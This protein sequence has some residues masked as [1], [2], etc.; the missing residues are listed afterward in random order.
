MSDLYFTTVNE[1]AAA[2]LDIT[3]DEYA[4]CNYIAV[5]S[6][7]PRNKV[8]GYCERTLEQK[9]AFIRIT[10]RGLTKMQNRM[11]EI[12]LLEKA[13]N[14]PLIRITKKWFEA[15]HGKEQSSQSDRE[16]SS[17]KQGTK[18][19]QTGNKVPTHIYS[20]Y[21]NNTTTTKETKSDFQSKNEEPNGHPPQP[22]NQSGV[23]YRPEEIAAKFGD[24]F[25]IRDAFS[26]SRGMPADIFE[27][28]LRGFIAEISGTGETYSN[29]PALVRHFL[30][31]S[32]RSQYYN[33]S[34]KKHGPTRR[35][36]ENDRSVSTHFDPAKG[37][38]K[39]KS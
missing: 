12:G 26:I 23:I 25:L 6:A 5:H 38:F 19:L 15:T 32:Q 22:S 7:N 24:D 31:W 21:S 1:V 35:V 17:Y 36:N 29:R 16:Q 10:T 2:A 3:R 33:Q 18:F 39:A 14:S 20:I 37:S 27:T 34:P 13:P 4:L 30:S 28:C 8:P 11:I 9:A